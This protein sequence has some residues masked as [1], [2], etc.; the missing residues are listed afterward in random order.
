MEKPFVGLLM[1]RIG[2]AY[3]AYQPLSVYKDKIS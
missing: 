3:F 2:K 1:V